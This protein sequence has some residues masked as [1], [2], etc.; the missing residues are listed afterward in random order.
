MPTILACLPDRLYAAACLA[1]P[2]LARVGS[3]AEA[4]SVLRASRV[5]G[6]ICDPA[7]ESPRGPEDLFW[8]ATDFP[9]VHVT[10]YT[11]LDAAVAQALVRLASAG[12]SD[13]VLF[14][15]EDSP[16]RWDELMIR[17]E[18]RDVVAMALRAADPVLR[19]VEPALRFALH[20]AFHNPR[21]FRTVDQL[22]AM[23]GTHRRGVYRKL[24]R[25]GIRAVR[26]WIDWGRL[27]NAFGLMRTGGRA[28]AQ[29]AQL[30]GY[31][32]GGDLSVHVQRVSRY[33]IA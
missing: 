21:K 25:A 15:Y 2:H 5:D 1:I 32:D 24:H 22:G 4:R 11:V 8:L 33:S 7:M 12:I 23:A 10:V 30:V 6:L 9:D 16:D 28:P 13:V 29:T 26:E 17:A 14:G 18:V 31:A 3:L 20:D 27:V 19:R